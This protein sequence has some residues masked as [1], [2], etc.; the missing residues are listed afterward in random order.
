MKRR[1]A[2]ILLASVGGTGL[3]LGIWKFQ[4]ARAAR[5]ALA[6]VTQH[7]DQM[8]ARLSGLETRV[9]A[10]LK[11]AEGIEADNAL[12]AAAIEQARAANVAQQ[13]AANAPLSI[14]EV[15]GRFRR[16]LATMEKDSETALRELLW[17]YDVGFP[18]AGG[19]RL[20]AQMSSVATALGRLAENYAPAQTALRE[21]LD[22][23]VQRLLS[24]PDEHEVS[25][26]YSLSRA[27]KEQQVL[28]TIHDQL[29]PGDPRRRS[30]AIYA[31]DQFVEARRYRDAAAGRPYASMSSSL[32][33]DAQMGK[34][35]RGFSAKRAATNIEVLAGAG[36]LEHARTLA[37]RL[38]N[39]DGSAE[40]RALLQHHL[41]RAG[42]P[43]LSVALQKTQP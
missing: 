20:R 1:F 41:D 34:Q 23:A 13:A 14:A 29:P 22:R 35:L 19:S 37:E 15:E 10:R 18:R 33:M 27:L 7:A 43:E 3:G 28:L 40:T 6:T 5:A 39:H 4:Q 38:L 9:Q 32:E 36:E 16:A 26:L 25:E 42:H 24:S 17:C 30:V 2:L 8:R 11:Q 21:R 12:L 31:F